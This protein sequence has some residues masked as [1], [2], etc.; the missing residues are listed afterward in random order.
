MAKKPLTKPTLKPTDWSQKLFEKT[1]KTL[2]LRLIC[3]TA[4]GFP[5][6]IGHE[7]MLYKFSNLSYY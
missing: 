3:W 7:V 2:R 4:D 5:I 6:N 1:E